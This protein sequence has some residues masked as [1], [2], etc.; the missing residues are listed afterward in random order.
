ML[1][2]PAHA[3]AQCR[4]VDA[5][6]PY[7]NY[8]KSP[9]NRNRNE[10]N[11]NPHHTL[12]RED[13]RTPQPMYSTS[14]TRNQPDIQT[15]T[16]K[17]LSGANIANPPRPLPAAIAA[18][19]HVDPLP[20]RSLSGT[21]R[22]CARRSAN[23]SGPS[24]TITAVCRGPQSAPW[25]VP[26]DRPPSRP[27]PRDPRLHHVRSDLLTSPNPAPQLSK[28]SIS[29]IDRHTD[30]NTASKQQR[31]TVSS[32]ST[33]AM[34]VSDALRQVTATEWLQWRSKVAIEPKLLAIVSEW[35]AERHR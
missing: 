23:T 7:I 34:L 21:R 18:V 31:S 25:S 6:Q 24:T 3:E 22:A 2:I 27:R 28:P 10:T 32:H 11:T 13:L 16:T 14:T 33:A 35:V 17:T 29:H 9:S 26:A 8:H 30:G 12:G 15:T 20:G 1:K 4:V 5:C 19:A